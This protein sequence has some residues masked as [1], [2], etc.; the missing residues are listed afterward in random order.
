MLQVINIY[1]TM[2]STCL[3]TIREI[4]YFL[5]LPALLLTDLVLPQSS[6]EVRCDPGARG[7][8]LVASNACL[9]VM[10]SS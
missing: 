6:E 3:L 4:I 5:V 10:K 1:C 9:S 8:V 2:Y 7:I